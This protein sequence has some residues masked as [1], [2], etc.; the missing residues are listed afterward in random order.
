M[1]DEFVDFFFIF[2][3]VAKPTASRFL[4]PLFPLCRIQKKG[5]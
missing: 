2:D 1:P 5:N 3:N 4:F